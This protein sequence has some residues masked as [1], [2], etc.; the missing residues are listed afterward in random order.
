MSLTDTVERALGSDLAVSVPAQGTAGPRVL[1]HRG[2]WVDGGLVPSDADVLCLCQVSVC[3]DPVSTIHSRNTPAGSWRPE[4]PPTLSGSALPLI[5]EGVGADSARPAPDHS[6]AQAADL[7]LPACTIQRKGLTQRASA[8]SA[9][10]ERQYPGTQ[11]ACRLTRAR[12]CSETGCHRWVSFHHCCYLVWVAA[13]GVS[14][15][16][17]K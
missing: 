2:G 1:A 3:A 4:A 14:D 12:G 11:P 10:L 13:C 16:R 6:Q 15:R 8:D 9:Q 7:G 17:E 5:S